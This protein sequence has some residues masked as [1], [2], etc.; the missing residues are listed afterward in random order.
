MPETSSASLETQAN[1]LIKKYSLGAL[2]TAVVPIP[3]ADLALLSALQL[4]MLRHLTSLYKVDFSKQLGKSLI[5]SLVGSVFPVS[6]VV[7]FVPVIGRV[8]GGISTAVFGGAS[9]FAVGKVFIQHFEAG[10][11]LLSFNPDKVRAYYEEQFKSGKS[12]QT[13]SHLEPTYEG[14]KP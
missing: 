2:A 13:G 5:A 4:A 10:G 6:L 7:G 9:T 12:L 3:L 8:W 14:V 1:S 11:T